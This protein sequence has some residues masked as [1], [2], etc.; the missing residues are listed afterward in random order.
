MSL[1]LSR[2]LFVV[3]LAAV[4]LLLLLPAE[5]M[6]GP[7]TE[8]KTGH[9]LTFAVLAVLGRSAGIRAVPL[10][11]GLLAYGALTELLQ[12][13]LP[14]GRFGDVRDLVADGAG[15]LLGL[16]VTV[17]LDRWRRSRVRAD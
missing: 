14:I 8:D 16:V 4:T 6:V 10:A 3:A 9:L 15:I 11:V 13:A 7:T 5:A 1:Q 12:A 17:L 2:V